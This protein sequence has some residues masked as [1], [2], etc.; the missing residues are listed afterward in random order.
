MKRFL[1][2]FLALPLGATTAF[3]YLGQIVGSFSARDSGCSGLAISDKYLFHLE[4]PRPY[5]VNRCHPI[6]GSVVGSFRL[7]DKTN[8]YSGL[9][10][11]SDGY[12]WVADPGHSIV[13]HVDPVTGSVYGFWRT[14]YKPYGLAPRCTGNGGSGTNALIVTDGATSF[15]FIHDKGTGSVIASFRIAH[16]SGHDCAY[17]WHNKVVWLGDDNYPYVVYGYRLNGSVHASF[18]IRNPGMWGAGGLTYKGGYL[19]MACTQYA[20]PD[21]IYRIHCPWGIGVEPASVGKVKALFR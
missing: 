20:G 13:Y 7:P 16:P 9:A 1:I 5:E 4:I 6:T 12:L 18:A 11:S 21:I 10:Y 15:A 2:I 14:S 3:S 19:W 17:D 8:Y